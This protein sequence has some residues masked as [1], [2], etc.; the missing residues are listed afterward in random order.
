MLSFSLGPLSIQASH[1]FLLTSL[2]VAA[3]VGHWAGRRDKVGIFGVLVDMLWVGL[4]A[5]RIAFVL[6]W[7]DLYR[8]APLAML[9][10]RDG[11][12]TAWAG[13]AAAMGFG[14]WRAWRRKELRNPLAAG[15][16]A[17]AMAWFMSGAPA[18]GDRT[19]DGSMPALA[20]ASLDGT[21]VAL[22]GLANGRPAVLNLWASWCPPCRREMPVLAAAQRRET[23]IAFIFANQ[24]EDAQA[25]LDYLR[26]EQLRLENVLLDPAPATSRA[27]GSSGMPTT[28]F[29]DGAG[30]L[31]DAHVGALSAA[32]LESKLAALRTAP[33]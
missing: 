2:L 4:A 8:A 27:A 11:G 26:G 3:G 28:L 33:P 16:L 12:F 7:F 21:Q 10:I 18:L 17:G 13:V 14:A 9:D 15:V 5:A 25:V 32:S 24:G 29:Y 1:F 6:E 30:R 19:A 22:P 31:V 23:G 20:L